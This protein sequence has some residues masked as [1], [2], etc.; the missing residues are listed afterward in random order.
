MK[1]PT[2]GRKV[3]INGLMVETETLDFFHNSVK[4]SRQRNSIDKL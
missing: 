3:K 4:A 1:K 2:D